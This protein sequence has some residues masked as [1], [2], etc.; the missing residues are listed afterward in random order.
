MRAPA[1]CLKSALSSIGGSQNIQ[2][3]YSRQYEREA[4]EFARN[5]MTRANIDTAAM[6]RFL[7]N[8]RTFGGGTD[9]PEFFLT[10]PYT[11]DRIAVVARDSGTARP[12]KRYWQL[13]AATAGLLLER[14]ECIDKAG[15]L[16]QPYNNLVR[17]LMLSRTG[18]WQDALK[19]LD[20]IDEP[21]ALGYKGLCLYRLG[22]VDEASEYLKNYHASAETA[23]A[24]ARIFHARGAV[25]EAVRMLEPFARQSA[26]V[27]YTL[28]TYYAQTDK[29]ALS[30]VAYARY[31]FRMR[32]Y[33]AGEYH[34]IT[35]LAQKEQ[36]PDELVAELEEMQKIARDA[37][38]G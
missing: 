19:L 17:G 27:T 7:V 25:D 21:V 33:E 5:V 10:H 15:S 11:E 20:G 28:G 34:I 26:R 2:L 32:N 8:L 35:A 36:L 4:D 23:L 6:S 16:P 24:L 18:Q 3:K 30:H 37:R 9:I 1:N 29:E 22:R 14:Q 13:Q 12:D 31:F 38:R